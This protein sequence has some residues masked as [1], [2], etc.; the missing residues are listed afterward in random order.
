MGSESADH[1]QRVDTGLH[2]QMHDQHPTVSLESIIALLDVMSTAT[3][4]SSLVWDLALSTKTKK[5]GDKV[6]ETNS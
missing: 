2:S 1:V 3:P 6:L 4:K 5:Q